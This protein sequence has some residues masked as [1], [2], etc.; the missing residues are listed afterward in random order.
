MWFY[1]TITKVD[2]LWNLKYFVIQSWGFLGSLLHFCYLFWMLRMFCWGLIGRLV[3]WLVVFLISLMVKFLQEPISFPSLG[4][5]LAY[6]PRVQIVILLFFFFL[7]FCFVCVREVNKS[8]KGCKYLP[9]QTTMP[10]DRGPVP[11][12]LIVHILWQQFQ[13]LPMMQASWCSCSAVHPLIDAGTSSLS[14]DSETL[15][16]KNTALVTFNMTVKT[17]RDENHRMFH[18]K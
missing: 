7:S 2:F 9:F 18:G 4:H 3:G 17:C 10:W 8:K 14:N 11:I 15:Q 6:F 16:S 1:N 5:V 12:N 13:P